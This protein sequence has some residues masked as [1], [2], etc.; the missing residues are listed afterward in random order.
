VAQRLLT[1]AALLAACLSAWGQTTARQQSM[2]MAVAQCNAWR[3]HTMSEHIGQAVNISEQVLP[4]D[5]AACVDAQTA[6]NLDFARAVG[7][8]TL[9]MV[10]TIT[11]QSYASCHFMA[12]YDAYTYTQWR[13]AYQHRADPKPCDLTGMHWN[14]ATSS[15][16]PD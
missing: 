11:M 8:H 7:D 15:Y 14:S 5:W 9:T 12:M 1:I 4:Q 16:V 3:D 10:E 6:T 13:E 2:Q